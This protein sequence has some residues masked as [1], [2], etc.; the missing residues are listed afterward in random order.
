[1]KY[2]AIFCNLCQHWV[3]PYCN[4]INKTE[5][6]EL[7]CQTNT[8]HCFNC[9][10][11]LYPNI[12]L[13]THKH[14]SN[15]V[16]LQNNCKKALKNKYIIHDDCKI[17]LKKVSGHETLSCSTCNHWI[18]KNCIGHFDNRADYQNFL[19]YYSTKP[20]DCPACRSEMLPFI[21]LSNE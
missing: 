6:K 14:N 1:M 11:E 21:E 2:E 9:S 15:D 8:W 12:L 18:H 20:W 4:W 13:S 3:H 16:Y 5:L 19:Y 10:S 17:C 7:G